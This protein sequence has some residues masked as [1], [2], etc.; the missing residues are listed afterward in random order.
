MDI[1]DRTKI[2]NGTPQK[3]FDLARKELENGPYTEERAKE[4]FASYS[5]ASLS[6]ILKNSR[7]IFSELYYGYG[8]YRNIILNFPVNPRL[9]RSEIAKVK[10]YIGVAKAKRLPTDKMEELCTLL[11]KR[12]HATSH[13]AILLNISA[14]NNKTDYFQEVFFDFVFDEIK[15]KDGHVSLEKYPM[16]DRIASY[17]FSLNCP[18][19]KFVLGF[20]L[21]T[22]DKEYSKVLYSITR[23][24]LAHGQSDS[25]EWIFSAVRIEKIVSFMMQDSLVVDT[26]HSISSDITMLWDEISSGRDFVRDEI[27][28]ADRDALSEVKRYVESSSTDIGSFVENVS[29]HLYGNE[30]AC[31]KYD[32]ICRN[33]AYYEACENFYL[34]TGLDADSY[35]NTFAIISELE[36]RKIFME[37][38]NDGSP[39][40]VIAKHIQTKKE[41]DQEKE[42]KDSEKLSLEKSLSTD[43]EEFDKASASESEFVAKVDD[44][45][46]DVVKIEKSGNSEDSRKQLHDLKEKLKEYEGIAKEKSYDDALDHLQDLREAIDAVDSDFEEY[47]EFDFASSNIFM[48]DL[49]AVKQ[50]FA[51]KKDEIK[52]KFDGKKKDKVEKPKEDLPT[53]IQNKALDKAAKSSEKAAER[54]EKNQKLKNA[55]NAVAEQPKKVVGDIQKT[56]DEFDKMDDNRRKEFLL[57]PGYRHKIFKN[58]KV[59]LMYGAAAQMKLSFVPILMVFRHLSKTKDK[60]IRN[61]LS[62]ELENEIKICEEKINDANSAGDNDKK[63]QL[64]RIRDKLNAE[65]T[66]VR[67]NS[68]YV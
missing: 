65:R 39:N 47:G 10:E 49:S 25:N 66:R 36:G 44:L 5:E 58:F 28:R 11:E 55:A 22:V 14:V 6:F 48:E 51:E 41:H 32:D 17:V 46:A 38:E 2:F 56:I 15:K 30:L 68:K 45:I 54:D 19:A 1:L 13:M 18:Y 27:A 50:K 9:Y 29:Y 26:M 62:M 53:K 57:K 52:D 16:L 34:E 61:E 40:A 31:M 23:P 3:R 60:R 4:F 64:M 43:R 20:Y 21:T 24:I 33:L 67:L 12:E 35:P 59:A 37:W 8:F 63:Y 7:N 42:L